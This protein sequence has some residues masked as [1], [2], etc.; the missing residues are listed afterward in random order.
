MGWFNKK[1]KIPEGS[2]NLELPELP[3]LPELPRF[4]TEEISPISQ[5]PRFPNSPLGKKLSQEI[6]KEAI[7]GGKEDR[8]ALEVE[9]FEEYQPFQELPKK[10]VTKEIPFEFKE[11]ARVVKKAEPIFIR[12]DKFEESLKIFDKTKK[13]ISE[14]EAGLRDIKRLKEEENSEL[15]NWESEIIQLKNQIEKVDRDIF[16]KIE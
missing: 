12:I 7:A 8:G 14:I 10:R 1:E 13:Q 6:I 11:A 5:L 2:K 9:D 3:K 16:S 15:E 4:G